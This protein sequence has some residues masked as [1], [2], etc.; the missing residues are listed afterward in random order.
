MSSFGSG[1]GSTSASTGGT[2]QL[3]QSLGLS[4]LIGQLGQSFG[5]GQQQPM[6]I[7]PGQMANVSPQQRLAMAMRAAQ[8]G[9]AAG[10][11]Q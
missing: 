6:T 10:P 9:G 11:Q 1:G 4:Q 8:M 3:M 2:Q 5:Q 7:Q